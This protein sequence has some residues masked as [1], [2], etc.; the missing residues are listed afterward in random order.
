MT[1]IYNRQMLPR[2]LHVVV[3]TMVGEERFFRRLH[4]SSV[5][6][7]RVVSK[8][9][10]VYCVTRSSDRLKVLTTSILVVVPSVL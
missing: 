3:C 7:S 5:L 1:L 9:E 8:K 6:M 10:V 4:V 2:R